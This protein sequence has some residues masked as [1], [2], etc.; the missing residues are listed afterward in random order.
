MSI[1]HVLVLACGTDTYIVQHKNADK[2]R[3][4]MS[5]P[6]W[7]EDVTHDFRLVN[8]GESAKLQRRYRHH[9]ITAKAIKTRQGRLLYHSIKYGNRQY[10]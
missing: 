4:F 1:P 8:N 2:L 6:K 9:H 5:N 7:M 3:K 10:I